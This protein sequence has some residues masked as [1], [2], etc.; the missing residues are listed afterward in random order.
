MSA[1]DIFGKTKITFRGR[2]VALKELEIRMEELRTHLPE[3]L[4]QKFDTIVKSEVL[5]VIKMK[6][7]VDGLSSKI[8]ESTRME[9]SVSGLTMTWKLIS[10]YKAINGFPVSVM[11]EK[12][13][14]RAFF[15]R[16]KILSVPRQLRKK[17][18]DEIG[19]PLSLSWLQ[20]G[21][22]VFSMG[23]EI[24]EYIPKRFI[25]QTVEQKH[26]KIQNMVNRETIKHIKKIL[27]DA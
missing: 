8:I 17:A 5:D 9:S 24:P 26:S 10:D 16:P 6:M 18:H 19:M 7:E 11:V 21:T 15:L 12:S 27:T 25:E 22:R 2:E 13:G 3:L 4:I 20:G 1:P 23:H 14:R